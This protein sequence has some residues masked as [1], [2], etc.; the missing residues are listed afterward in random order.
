MSFVELDDK[1]ARLARDLRVRGVATK[2]VISLY[3][4][5]GW[6]WIVAYHAALRVGAVV[7]PINALLTPDEVNYILSD[8]GAKLIF[9]DRGRLDS[10]AAA[11]AVHSGI[12]TVD[13]GEI[14]LLSS[15]G[16]GIDP[17]GV[18]DPDALSTICYTS[19]TTGRPKG[20]MLS[21]RN[22]LMNAALTGLMH[23]RSAAD[24]TVTALP[25]AHV[26]GNVVMNGSIIAGATLVLIPAFAPEAVLEAIE[27]HRA[28]RFEGVPTMYYRLLDSPALPRTNVGTLQY[29]TVGGQTMPVDKMQAVEARLGC[30]LLELWGMSEIGGLGTTFPWTGPRTLGSI[31]I[32]L[33]GMEVRTVNAET[34]LPTA[35]GEAGELQIRG[36]TVMIGYLGNPEATRETLDANGWLSTGD[37]AR[38]D[39]QGQVFV[40][41]RMKDVI[42]TSGNNVY[43]A[44]IERAI[45]SLAGVAMVGVGRDSH[46]DKGEVPHAFIVCETGASLTAEIV[47]DHCRGLLAPYKIPRS[48]SFVDDLPKTSSGK[49][50]RRLLG[51]AAFDQTPV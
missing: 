1:V 44:E 30:P 40:I 41:D 8:C 39:D 28:T 24:T 35:S 33:P 42:L 17:A 11:D 37:V 51:K 13:F 14:D 6:E 34:R 22:V 19:G 31:G 46:P 20:A 16:E 43:P 49:I 21:H 23:G 10:L 15:T 5:V 26:Y 9:A 27:L 50:L 2:D 45:S 36:A 47:V 12:E 29:C 3:G 18:S 4:P 7:N 25:L 38:I 32:A 48:I